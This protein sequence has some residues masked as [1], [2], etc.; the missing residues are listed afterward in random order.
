MD[1]DENR[2]FAAQT[3]NRCWELLESEHRTADDDLE[4]LTSAFASRYHWGLVGGSEKMITGDWM[5]AR[6][7]SALGESSIALRF[8]Q[9]AY[10][11]AQAPRTPDWL[12][13]STA[14]GVA[15]A[16]AGA[17][18]QVQSDEWRQRALVLV[19]RIEDED[20][21]AIVADQVNSIPRGA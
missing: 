15:R 19:A 11:E 8:A 21:R 16:F 17:G 12:V 7:A 14:E 2:T 18:D 3:Y 20:D 13:A 9:R 1:T 5:V 6:A 10:G 4:L